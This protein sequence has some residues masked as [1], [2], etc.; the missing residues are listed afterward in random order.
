[1]NYSNVIITQKNI[2]K[3]KIIKMIM[4]MIIIMIIIYNINIKNNKQICY[5]KH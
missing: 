5:N 3:I 2:K 1:M 4:I